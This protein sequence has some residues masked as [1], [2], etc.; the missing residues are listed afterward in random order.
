M[1]LLSQ[2]KKSEC[3][4]AQP[5]SKVGCQNHCQKPVYHP[6][7]RLEKRPKT[8]TDKQTYKQK[9]TCRSSANFVSAGQKSFLLSRR[10]MEGSYILFS[11]SFLQNSFSDERPANLLDDPGLTKS[12]TPK[13][14]NPCTWYLLFGKFLLSKHPLNHNST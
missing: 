5:S 9:L 12:N 11:C 8:Q 10:S 7:R 3:G 14:T 2:A 13:I 4:T 1:A 6:I